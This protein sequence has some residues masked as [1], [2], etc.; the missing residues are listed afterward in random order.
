MLRRA[1]R[2]FR[3]D[4]FELDEGRRE[5][6]RWGRPIPIEPKPRELLILLLER[7]PFAASRVEIR[8]RLWP[9]VVVTGASL[10][11]AVNALRRVLG[12]RRGIVRTIR[13]FGYGLDADVVTDGAEPSPLETTAA[14]E[15]CMAQ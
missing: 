11:R 3:F 8:A 12:G 2:I 1:P 10:D 7:H 4:D 9:D 15:R 6:R 14:T 5:L 13:G